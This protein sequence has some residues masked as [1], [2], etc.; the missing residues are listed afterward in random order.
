MTVSISHVAAAAG[1]YGVTVE[2]VSDGY[3]FRPSLN[4]FVDPSS[5]TYSQKKIAMAEGLLENIGSYTA[6]ITNLSG[7]A[8]TNDPG[9]CRFR[10]HNESSSNITVRI[11]ECDVVAGNLVTLDAPIATIATPEQVKD[12][13]VEIL[14]D[15]VDGVLLA[16]LDAAPPKNPTIEQALM[17]QYM[18]T[19]NRSVA[20]STSERF[21]NDAGSPVV[22]AAISETE[23][24]TTKDRL[25]SVT[26]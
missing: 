17:L 5:V 26:S 20:S 9:L 21:Y 3:M 15:T 23:E 2:R 14:T 8:A 1:T 22:E 10:I 7:V 6:A 4:A 16:E 24:T 18:R 25:T 13:V 11:F 19:R 12:A